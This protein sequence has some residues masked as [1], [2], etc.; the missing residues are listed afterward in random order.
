MNDNFFE[1]EEQKL[2]NLQK[3]L[4]YSF[5]QLHVCRNLSLGLV[6]K[7]RACKVTC[8]KG[9]MGVTL[10]APRRGGKCE[11]MNSHTTKGTST[12]G[13]GIIVDFRISESNCK[14]QN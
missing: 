14:G 3:N 7:A 11:R 2:S 1:I 6:T 13:V 5:F 9:G 10:H 4:I 12:L 8:Q